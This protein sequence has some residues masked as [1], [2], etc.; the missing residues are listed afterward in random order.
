MFVKKTTL[1]RIPDVSLNTCHDSH[2]FS[3]SIDTGNLDFNNNLGIWILFKI[4]NP[5][6]YATLGNLEVIEEKPLVGEEINHVK[7][8]EKRD[9]Y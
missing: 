8:K 1:N 7:E 3:F 6:G 9:G 5:D 4:S 2:A